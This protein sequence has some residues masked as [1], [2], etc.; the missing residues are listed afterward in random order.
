MMRP[1]DPVASREFPTWPGRPHPGRLA[2]DGLVAARRQW[3]STATIA[4]VVAVA[5]WIVLATTGQ[6]AAAERAV[7]AHIDDVGTRLLVLFDSSGSARIQPTS[8]AQIGSL[9][10]V[11]WSFGLGPAHDVHNAAVPSGPAVAARTFVGAPGAGAILL[12]AGRLPRPG[13]AISGTDASDVLGLRDVAGTVSDGLRTWPVVGRF[14]ATGPLANLAANVL[15]ADDDTVPSLSDDVSTDGLRFVYV[16]ADDVDDVDAL[17]TA[18]PAALRAERPEDVTLELPA[19]ALELRSVVA[20]ELGRSSRQLLLIILAVSAALTSITVLSSTAGRRRD[21]GRRR[22]L[23]ASRS[24]IVGH[25]LVQTSSGVVLGVV[26][27]GCV[28]LVTG[29]LTVSSSADLAFPAAV[30]ILLAL[31]SL[32]G[33]LPAALVAAWRDPLQVLRVP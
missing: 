11:R 5:C 13:E 17:S 2:R 31:S 32:A 16:M 14:D 33:A 9:R 21:I 25:V 18:A 28:S 29:T 19:S 7:V 10:A 24:A 23:G 30:G 26:M 6:A 20:G 27:G 12:T 22:A 15:V 1:D 3:I 8:V 4:A